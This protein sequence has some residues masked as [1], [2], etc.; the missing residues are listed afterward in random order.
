MSKTLSYAQIRNKISKY[1]NK[2]YESYFFSLDDFKKKY[3][4]INY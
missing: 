2:K 4:W 1:D 3:N